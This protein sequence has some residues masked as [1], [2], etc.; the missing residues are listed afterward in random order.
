M[1]YDK[2]TLI[3]HLLVGIILLEIYLLWLPL[4][5]VLAFL[6]PTWEILFRLFL[7]LFWVGLLI[8]G[9]YIN[10]SYFPLELVLSEEL[11]DMLYPIE[12]E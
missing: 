6:Y 8:F 10:E 3:V 5:P 2:Y 4:L 7:I 9:L 11:S 1:K 12:N